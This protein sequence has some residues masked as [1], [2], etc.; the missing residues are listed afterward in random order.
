MRCYMT[1]LKAEAVKWIKEE[2]CGGWGE[3]RDDEKIGRIS[4]LTE[5]FNLTDEDLK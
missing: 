4:V 5:F 3:F 1:E 2:Q